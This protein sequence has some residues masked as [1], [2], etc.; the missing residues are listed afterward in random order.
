LGT[1]LAQYSTERKKAGC[2]REPFGIKL[3]GASGAAQEVFK[4]K[5]IGL[6]GFILAFASFAMAQ[7]KCFKHQGDGFDHELRLTVNGSSV[8][9]ELSVGHTNSEMPTRLYKFT[10]TISKNV[11]TMRFSG[12]TVPNAFPKIGN[13]MTATLAGSG[14]SLVVKLSN[15]SRQVYSATFE[16]CS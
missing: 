16:P 3:A 7:E 4:V 14:Q 10:G 13:R 5:M 12:G 8:T 15:G 9:G 6:I 11:I 1:T 2:A